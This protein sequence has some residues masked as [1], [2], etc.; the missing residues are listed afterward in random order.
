MKILTLNYEFPPLGG[1]AG[2]VTR[3]LGSQL[4][5]MGHEVDVVSM[6][7]KGLAKEETVGGVRVFRV[8]AWRRKRATCNMPEMFTYLVGARG[9]LLKLT[10]RVAYDI[11]HCHFAIPTGPLATMLL[12]RRGLPYV[13]TCHGSDIPMYNADRFTLAHRIT[14]PFIR[15]IMRKAAAVVSPS[16]FLK[17]LIDR[18]VGEYGARVIPNGIDVSTFEPG[19]KKKL[20]LMT[21]RLLPRKGFQHVLQAIEG[22]ETDFEVH[23]AGDGPM[24]G[25]LQAI[26]ARL[27]TKVVFHGWLHNGSDELRQLYREASVYCLPSAKENASIALLEGMLCGAAVLTTN[28]SGC[29]E[30]VGDCGALVDPGDVGGIRKVLTAW[31]ADREATAELGRRARQR[32]LDTYDWRTVAASYAE[33]FGEFAGTGN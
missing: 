5:A 9:F 4:V 19:E 10:K 2:A 14:R 6:R 7:Y 1:G 15:R 20:L 25:E 3:D 12:R 26:A 13:L 32:V 33:A 18:E 29:P 23:I 8:P 16:N 22:I 17:G 21:G 27:K 30:T 31:F 11:V 24:M 28:V